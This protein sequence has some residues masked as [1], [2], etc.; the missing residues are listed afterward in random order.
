ME[1]PKYVKIEGEDI[2]FRLGENNRYWF[3]KGQFGVDYKI[4]G[5]KLIAKDEIF[6]EYDGFELTPITKSEYYKK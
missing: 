2:K 4:V 1:L 6:E 3:D 5:E